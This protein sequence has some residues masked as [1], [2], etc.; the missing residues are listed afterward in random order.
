M[1]RRRTKVAKQR[2]NPEA[3]RA[4]VGASWEQHHLQKRKRPWSRRLRNSCQFPGPAPP[5][6]AATQAEGAGCLLVSRPGALGTGQ[7]PALGEAACSDILL[8]PL[9]LPQNVVL[10][11]AVIGSC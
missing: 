3:D 8:G 7:G 9:I 4:P 2:L 1:N 10:A 11:E 6:Q 5:Q